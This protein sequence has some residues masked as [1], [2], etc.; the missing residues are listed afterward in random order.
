MINAWIVTM[1][2]MLH[3]VSVCFGQKQII[4]KLMFIIILQVWFSRNSFALCFCKT[5]AW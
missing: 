2:D 4:K 3:P 1:F 5:Q